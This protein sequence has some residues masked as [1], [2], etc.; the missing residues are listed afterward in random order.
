VWTEDALLTNLG[1]GAQA[2]PP[3]YHRTALSPDH[4]RSNDYGTS[5]STGDTLNTKKHEAIAASLTQGQSVALPLLAAGVKKQDAAAA[6]GVCPQTVSTWLQQPDFAA[7]LREQ[8]EYLAG[9]ASERLRELVG[10]AVT[11]V[12]KLLESGSES[13]KLKAAIY[14]LDRVVLLAAADSVPALP[15]SNDP[16]QLLAALGVNC[17]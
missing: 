17:S 11:T 7:A 2:S 5:R 16:R 3:G 4:R 9:L 6:V 1:N 14:V 10:T 13:V 15:S 12:E 8:R